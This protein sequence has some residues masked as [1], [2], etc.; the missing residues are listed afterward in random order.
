MKITNARVI[1]CCP[2]RNFVT[3]KIETDQGLTGIGDATLNGRELAVVSYLEDHVVPCLIGRD[4][5]QIED[6][7]QYLYRGAYWRRGPVTMSAIAAV[8]TALWDIKAKAANLPLY[9][10]LGGK[11]RTGVMVYGHANGSDIGHTV[12]EVLRYKEMGYKAIRAQ[13]GVPGLNKVYGVSRDRL[14]YEPADANLPSEHDWSTERYLDHTPKLFDKVREAVGPDIHLLHD[15]HH[16][17]TPIEAG[18]LGKSLE[19]FRLFW[20]EDATPAEDQRAFRLIRQHTVTPLAV[21][22]IFNSIWDCKALL[23]E[24]LIDYI[25]ATVVHAGGITHLRRIADFAA[26]H[27]VRTGCH[28]ATDLSPACMGAALHFDIWVPNF[29]IQEYMRHTEETDAVFPH[30]YTFQD[31]MMYP[32]DAPGHGVDIDETLAAKYPY[33]RAYL[34]VNRLAHDGT[35]WHW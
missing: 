3:L 11:S 2:G 16:R 13:S 1:V 32:G 23:E 6:I 5:H 7:W 22:E 15:V 30:A 19:P 9:Q 8:D 28:G 34:P 21:G 31:G 26:L 25:R 18:R 14:F 33:Q 27:Q 4:A 35:L 29:G 17:L 12:E 20:M 24:Q 10:L